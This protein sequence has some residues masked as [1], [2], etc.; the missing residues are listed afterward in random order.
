M[1]IH[2]MCHPPCLVPPQGVVHAQMSRC[3]ILWQR[4]EGLTK[5]ASTAPMPHMTSVLTMGSAEAHSS[6]SSSMGG[7]DSSSGAKATPED[8]SVAFRK[9]P[10]I[11]VAVGKQT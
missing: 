8:M 10:M 5:R 6:S 7:A 2:T 1:A 3:D 9:E 11:T 4:Q